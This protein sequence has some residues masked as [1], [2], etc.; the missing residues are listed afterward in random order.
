MRRLAG[1]WTRSRSTR[2][3]TDEVP[4]ASLVLSHRCGPRMEG[5]GHVPMSPMSPTDSGGAGCRTEGRETGVQMGY[6]RVRDYRLAEKNPC[7]VGPSGSLRGPAPLGVAEGVPV[8][9]GVSTELATTSPT[10][11]HLSHLNT[12]ISRV[13]IPRLQ[14]ERTHRSSTLRGLYRKVALSMLVSVGPTRRWIQ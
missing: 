3:R 4:V 2:R 5:P 9:W 14:P 8:G 13:C 1:S 7:G 12:C 11:V 10:G 6:V